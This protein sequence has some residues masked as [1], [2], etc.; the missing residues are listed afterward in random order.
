[1][2]LQ[3]GLTARS[4]SLE[5]E[6]PV[7]LQGQDLKRAVGD[8]VEQMK[9]HLSVAQ[10]HGV[11]IAIENHGH[12]LID[13]PDS[14]K[15]LAE[16]GHE[17]GLG[18]ALAPYHLEH[19]GVGAQALGQLITDLGAGLDMF[20]AWQYG[21]GCMKPLPKEQELLQMPGRGSPGFRAH[22]ESPAQDPFQGLD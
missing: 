18:V 2:P 13:H 12:N 20:Y 3:E 14:L 11:R 19:Y 8:F 1:M 10:S 21:M 17:Q 22:P 15:W 6:G 4:L 7:G 16:L 5:V 9:P